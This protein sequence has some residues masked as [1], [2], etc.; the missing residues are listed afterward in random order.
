MVNDVSGVGAQLVTK[1]RAAGIRSAADFV[2]VGFVSNGRSTNVYF[3]LTSGQRAHVPGIGRV[4]AERIDQWRRT[5]VAHATVFQP[6]ALPASELSVIDAQFLAE[7]RQS[8]SSVRARHSKS[9][10]RSP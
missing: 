4:K 9:P 8:G 7:E 3:R 10:T 5:Q 2:G 6:S 1:L